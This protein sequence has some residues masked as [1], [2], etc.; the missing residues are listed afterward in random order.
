M[1]YMRS[2][3][4]VNEVSELF[5]SVLQRL[6]EASQVPESMTDSEIFWDAVESQQEC[7]SA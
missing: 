5:Q 4:D 6:S 3:R 2:R 1:D 7:L